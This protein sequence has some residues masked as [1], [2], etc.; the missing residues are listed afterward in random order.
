VKLKTEH[1]LDVAADEFFDKVFYND[2]FNDSLFEQLDF[3]ER[4][5]LSQDD[6]GDTIVRS[7]RQVPERE[8]PK[9]I[10][11]V[12]GAARLEY[13]ENTTYHKDSGVVDI[14]IV[15]SIKPDKVKISGKLW[16]EPA[17]DGQ[18]K[19]MFELDVN[20]KIFGVGG[21]LEKQIVDET[22]QSYDKSAELTQQYLHAN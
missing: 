21:V 9:A 20:V 13:T 3:K 22:R 12:M 5:V 11:K 4:S 15:S 1:L 16:V 6:R 2:E 10:L 18:C 7:V 19:R 8:L 17:G 14:D